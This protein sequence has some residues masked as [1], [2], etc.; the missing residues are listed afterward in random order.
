MKIR[1]R[2]A[3]S[4]TGRMHVGNLR[5]AL[6]AYLIAKHE[7][8]TFLLRIEDTDQGRLVEGATEI[9]Y[10]TMQETGLIHDE[11]PDKDGGYGPYVQSERMKAGIYMEYAKQ[12]V[13]KGEAYYCFCDQGRLDSLKRSVNGE[14]I[15]QYDKH[16]L[17][18]SAEEV[19]ANLAAG[20]PF[21]IRQNN[22]RTG[23]T[24]FHD[25]IYGDIS[26][27]NSE[28]DDMVLIKSDGFPTYNF[29]NVVDDHLM[30]ITHV[31]RGQEYLSSSPKYNRLYEAF[32]WEVPVYV[33]CPTITNEEHQKL[34]KRS[35]HAS[36]EDLLE[37]GFVTE[38]VVNFV[39][40]LGW[41]PEGEQEIFS[42]PE[43]AGVFDYRRINK[44]PA[45][46][47]MTKLRWMNGEYL[48]AMAP[49]VF[50][51]KAEPY[52]E[53]YL[54]ADI[55]RRR[56]AELV[57]TRIETFPDIEEMVDFFN[58]LPEYDIAMY[59]NKKSKSTAE[60]AR[61]VLTEVLPLLEKAESWTNDAL[62]ELLKQYAE[63]TGVKTGHVMW[64][65]RTALSGKLMTPAGATEILELLGR[66]E[67]LRRLETGIQKLA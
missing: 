54:T 22:P 18:L 50:Y 38:A 5:T 35:G 48:K 34:S 41:S 26:V 30:G 42:L 51:E 44:S 2:Y 63:Q 28:L 11:G 47:D 4:P 24:T 33:H 53:R 36:F 40:L 27:D 37:Q 19:Q 23:T 62:F 9:I 29:A 10:R 7:N 65:I 14:T 43:L 60:S 39:A 66:E 15:M 49:E 25:E 16:C 8:G 56:V 17:S 57:R 59:T 52:L 13:E 46:F 12:L 55:D 20:K 3:P 32:G 67:A 58:A 61:K 21:V 45:V 6:Y 1:T 31:V 64:P